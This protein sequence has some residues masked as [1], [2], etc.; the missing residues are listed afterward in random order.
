LLRHNDVGFKSNYLKG[1]GAPDLWGFD[2]YPQGFDCS[3]PDDW[4]QLPGSWGDDHL[5]LDPDRPSFSPG[6]CYAS[7]PLFERN[8]RITDL[9]SGCRQSS[10]PELS[11]ASVAPATS[12][13]HS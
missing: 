8:A 2:A 3:T 7:P 6:T 1:P 11:M 10:R 9:F 5:E 13:A 12:G 4:H